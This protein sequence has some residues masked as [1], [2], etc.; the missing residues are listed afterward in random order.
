M[1]RTSIRNK[2]RGVGK[3]PLRRETVRVLEQPALAIVVGGYPKCHT[4]PV[5][6]TGVETAGDTPVE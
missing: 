2:K 4:E 1:K 3:L 5:S 6:C